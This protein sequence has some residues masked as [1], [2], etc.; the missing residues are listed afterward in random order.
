MWRE[1]NGMPDAVAS[2]PVS[3][4]RTRQVYL[5]LIVAMVAASVPSLLFCALEALLAWHGHWSWASRQYHL[6]AENGWDRLLGMDAMAYMWVARWNRLV[7]IAATVFMLAS[8]ARRRW[9]ALVGFAL[10][11]YGVILAADLVLRLRYHS[12]P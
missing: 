5:G 4:R 8:L 6:P 10:L 7:T 12:L 3:E 2:A 1:S 11:P 9:R